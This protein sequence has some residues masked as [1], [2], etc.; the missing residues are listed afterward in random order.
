MNKRMTHNQTMVDQMN[1]AYVK[2][3]GHKNQIFFKNLEAA[4]LASL[5]TD[6][7][8]GQKEKAFNRSLA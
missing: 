8:A 5:E 2:F 7:P 6:F 3:L 4:I 1:E